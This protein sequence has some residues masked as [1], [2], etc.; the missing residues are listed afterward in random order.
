MFTSGLK[1][2]VVGIT[3]II[4]RRGLAS[5][6]ATEVPKLKTFK[7]YRWNPDHPAEKPKLQE[8]QVDLNK[9]G[10]MVLDALLK[11]KNEQ[12]A[13]LTFRRS[14]R[15]GI[16]GSCAMN[17]GGRNT[18]ACLC[19]IDTDESKQT[20]IYPLPHMY[21]VK[22][23][24]PDL[25]HFYQQYKSIQ[26]YLQRSKVPEDGKENLQSIED[27]EKLNGLYECIL[28]A[29]CSTACPS[30]WWNQEEYL[31]PAVLMQAYRWLIDSRDEA[32]AARKQMLQ[33][34]MSLY[35]CHTIMNCTRTCPKGLNPGYAIAEIKKALIPA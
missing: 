28:C 33:N 5:E 21:I 31:G 24:V 10:P 8:Y 4:S 17:I 18:L 34:S 1:R 12:D 6:A 29:C 9:C 20:K 7:I 22:D 14:C 25:T 16:C 3:G 30:Y 11:I 32:S 13:T 26:P 19:R 35:R 27:R 15:E 23:L 2:S